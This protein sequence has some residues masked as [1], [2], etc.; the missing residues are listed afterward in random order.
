[1]VDLYSCFEYERRFLVVDLDIIDRIVPEQIIQGYLLAEDG[2]AVRVRLTCDMDTAA[3]K[4]LASCA[5]DDMRKAICASSDKFTSAYIAVK[6]PPISGIRYEREMELPVEVAT[7]V[8]AHS[9]GFVFKSRYPVISDEDLWVVDVFHGVN[10]PLVLAECERD[11]PVVELTVPKFVGREV[12]DDVRYNSDY[13][14]MSPFSN[15]STN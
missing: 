7:R 6:S 14:A 10:S 4:T 2:Y 9:M 15:W 5:S 8:C 1:M 13:L 11:E 3:L 12:T